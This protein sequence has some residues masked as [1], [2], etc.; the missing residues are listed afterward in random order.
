MKVRRMVEQALAMLQ[1]AAQ[2]GDPYQ[3]AILDMQM[4]DM[5]GVDLAGAIQADPSIAA[6]RR[7]L[8][9]CISTKV[10]FEE[11]AKV[12]VEYILSKPVRQSQLYNCLV[13][14]MGSPSHSS[15]S[16]PKYTQEGV[17]EHFSARVLLVE[18]NLVNQA[19]AVG[20]LESLG[21]Q[22]DVA[23]NG[24]EA[25]TAI[26][27]TAYDLIFM[28]CQMPEMDGFEATRM[29]REREKAGSGK[30]NRE[31]EKSVHIPI[32]ALTADA[33]GGV[34]EQCLAAGMDDYLFK[35]FTK[36]QLRALLKGWL[37]KKDSG[38]IGPGKKKRGRKK[39]AR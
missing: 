39:N 34:R 6:V 36:D 2:E 27:R 32:I 30:V 15:P 35:P 23:G 14:L 8:L 33:L 4:S 5:N 10:E 19:V 1:A 9:S 22:V 7:V 11:T 17:T 3:L 28:D 20:M 37:P 38:G 31:N 25:V 24:R 21:C 18:D 13:T 26:P 29:I 12:G 16:A